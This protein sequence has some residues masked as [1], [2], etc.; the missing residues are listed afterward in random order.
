MKVKLAAGGLSGPGAMCA[1]GGWDEGRIWGEG[2]LEP[3]DFGPPAENDANN[4]EADVAPFDFGPAGVIAPCSREYGLFHPIDRALGRSELAA[5]S[6]FH[7]HE[8]QFRAVPG[9]DIDFA[10]A[11]RR[12]VPPRHN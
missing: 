11:R 12:P 8:D 3:F 10:A 4:I 2:V 6:G 5:R 1:F 9:H 7:F